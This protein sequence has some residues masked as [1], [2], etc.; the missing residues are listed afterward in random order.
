MDLRV[1]KTEK[2]IRGALYQ[3]ILEK[4]VEKISVRE[5]SERAEINKTTFYAHYDTIYDLIDRLEQETIES[6]IEHLDDCNLLFEKP[7]TFIHNMYNS[8]KIC[9]N[10]R[11]TLSSSNSQRF[12]EKLNKAIRED[13]KLRNINMDQYHNL[14]A[15][16]VFLVNG[17]I[18][19]QKRQNSDGTSN[20]IEYIATFVKGGINALGLSK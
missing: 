11:F 17:I 16:L 6:I 20:E 13:P 5:L 14:S 8:M 15:L 10:I 9:P 18:G 4:P 19:L 2:A 12:I 7:E 3:L 1:K